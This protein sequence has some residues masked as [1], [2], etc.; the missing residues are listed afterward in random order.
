[1]GGIKGLSK[2]IQQHAEGAY[3]ESPIKAY[4]GR[5]IALD[6]TMALYQFLIAVRYG[7]AGGMMTNNAGETTSHIPGFFYRTIRMMEQGI[8]PIYI[9]DGKPPD[10]KSHEL[11]K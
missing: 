3:K 5:T 2:L 6:A 4:F 9:F 7:D 11:A 1:M 10:F 8:K